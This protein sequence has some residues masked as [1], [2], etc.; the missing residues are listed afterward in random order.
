MTYDEACRLLAPPLEFLETLRK[1]AE[2]RTYTDAEIVLKKERLA[3]IQK[4]QDN[5][6]ATLA[7]LSGNDD[8]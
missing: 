5:I 8:A 2:P 1:R 4:I 3:E 7:K 6:D